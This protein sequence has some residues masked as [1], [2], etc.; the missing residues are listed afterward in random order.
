MI[1]T[2][3]IADFI[4]N[5][6]IGTETEKR[7][8]NVM[9]EVLRRVVSRLLTMDL[10]FIFRFLLYFIFSFSFLFFS[11]FRA[12]RVRVDWSRCHISHNLMV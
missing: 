5:V 12:T 2:G 8:D 10:T 7:Y 3:N 1:E 9:K 6:M 11:I 4:N